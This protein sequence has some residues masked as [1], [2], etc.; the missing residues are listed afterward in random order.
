VIGPLENS[1]IATNPKTVN[2]EDNDHSNN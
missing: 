2:V 1:K